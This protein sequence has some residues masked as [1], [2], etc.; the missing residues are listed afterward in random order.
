MRNRIL[1]FLSLAACFMAAGAGIYFLMPHPHKTSFAA[2]PDIAPDLKMTT[3][4]GKPLHL[5]DFRGHRIYVHFWASWCEPCRVELPQLLTFARTR[6]DDI[7]VL[8][9]ADEQPADAQEFLEKLAQQSPKTARLKNV[10]LIR[11][12]DKSI[13]AG[14]FFTYRYPETLVVDENFRMV[15]KFPGPHV[16]SK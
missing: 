15:D 7:F 10:Y 8:V 12:Q 16:W 1:I 2:A 4:N 9:T 13:S 14:V 3:L 11:D 5:S 6:P